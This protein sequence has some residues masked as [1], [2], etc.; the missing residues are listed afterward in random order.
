[1]LTKLRTYLRDLQ[2]RAYVALQ[3]FAATEPVRLR[4]ALVSLVLAGGV[5]FPALAA[6]QT[7]QIIAG[8][9]AVALPLAV[10]ETT[11]QRVTPAG[12]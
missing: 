8:I 5:L 1:M 10:G 11:R 4:A 12:K 2:I 3:V 7:A 9:G 6:E